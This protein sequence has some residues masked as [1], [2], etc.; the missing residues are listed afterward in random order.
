MNDL[1]NI[2]R[3]MLSV[4]VI[5]L[6]GYSLISGN[7]SIMTYTMLFL[8]AMIVTMGI[9]EINEDRKKMRMISFIVSLF[10]FYV[11]IESLLLN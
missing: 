11:A 8:G 3:V 4:I 9:A 6:A 1:L 2:I 10:I 7:H 5:A